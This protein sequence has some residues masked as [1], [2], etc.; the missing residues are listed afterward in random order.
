[1]DN[2]FTVST[3][4]GGG[5]F[6]EITNT[7]QPVI[8][9][10]SNP[11]YY[12]NG[13]AAVSNTTAV[14]G[15]KDTFV[16][17]YT[18]QT[19]MSG[20]V[21]LFVVP[22][23]WPEFEIDDAGQEG[24]TTYDTTGSAVIEGVDQPNNWTRTMFVRMASMAV[25]EKL[26]ITYGDT[27]GGAYPD[28][29]INVTDTPTSKV[30]FTVAA[31]DVGS[32]G[33]GL[34]N[35]ERITSQPTITLIDLG[36]MPVLGNGSAAA[37]VLYG[38][39]NMSVGLD[40]TNQFSLSVEYSDTEGDAPGYAG[41]I[42]NVI[43][44]R[45]YT[46]YN[47]YGDI[48]ISSNG[49]SGDYSN[50]FTF[51]FSTFATQKQ[52][53]YTNNA[54][55]VSNDFNTIC[56][57]ADLV[58]YRWMTRAVSGSTAPVYYPVVFTAEITI[59]TEAPELPAF[60]VVTNE[61]LS[62][63]LYVYWTNS[64][65]SDLDHYVIEYG[66]NTNPPSLNQ[67]NVGT[68]T[69]TLIDF[70]FGD[71]LYYVRL[72]AYDSM[73]NTTNSVWYTCTPYDSGPVFYSND[74]DV[75][76]YKFDDPDPLWEWGQPT[77][78][79]TA[80]SPNNCWGT[81][82][83]GD[84][85]YDN[86]DES[87]YLTNI[88]LITTSNVLM[89]FYHWYRTEEGR[90]G[91]TISVSTNNKSSWE[92]I[93]P[94]VGN[95]DAD[96]KVIGQ[97][98]FTG[99]KDKWRYV[100][101]DLTPYADNVVDIRFRFVS[102]DKENYRPG[103]YFD[104]LVIEEGIPPPAL[105]IRVNT[106]IDETYVYPGETNVEA[107][108]FRLRA[109]RSGEILSN[110]TID[111]WTWDAADT[112][113]IARVGLYRDGGTLGVYSTGDD[114][115]VT[116]LTPVG[117]NTWNAGD[118]SGQGIDIYN[119]GSGENFLVLLDISNNAPGWRRF[120]GRI[121]NTWVSSSSGLKNTEEIMNY[122]SIIVNGNVINA[123]VIDEVL[124][125]NVARGTSNAVILYFHLTGSQGG[126]TL[127]YF[128]VR[129]DWSDG[130]SVTNG[131]LDAV[132]LWHDKGGTP[133]QWDSGD[134][135][136]G[137]LGADGDTEW[138]N[139][140]S[141]YDIY[142]G[143]AGIDIILTM[144]VKTNAAQWNT[145]DARIE[146]FN[147]MSSINGRNTESLHNL[148]PDEEYY[149]ETGVMIKD[150]VIYVSMNTNFPTRNMN[151]GETNVELLAF[152][153]FEEVSSLLA[154]IR[155]YNENN[156]G[157]TSM[158]N[159][160]FDRDI[161]N[162]SLYID[163]GAQ[164]N[165]WDASDTF[166]TVLGTTNDYEWTN[167][168]PVTNIDLYNSGNGIDLLI[169]ADIP[170]SIALNTLFYARIGQSGLQSTNGADNIESLDNDKNYIAR[171]IIQPDGSGEIMNLVGTSNISGSMSNFG[172]VNIF[173]LDEGMMTNAE[174][175]IT[176]PLGFGEPQTND[177]ASN[178]YVLG[179]N[180]LDLF[181][182]NT[183]AFD[184]YPAVIS[185]GGPWT[186]TWSLGDITSSEEDQFVFGYGTREITHFDD[187]FLGNGM[188][189]PAT[190]SN[191]DFTFKS[192]NG[193][194][195][196]TDINSNYQP[197]VSIIDNTG[198]YGTGT[199]SISNTNAM[200]MTTD[201]FTITYTAETN[202]G[203]AAIMFAVPDGWDEF[204][205]DSP[206]AQGYVTVDVTG[207]AVVDDYDCIE[208][209]MGKALLVIMDTLDTN[210][211]VIVTY[212]DTSGGSY[213]QAA[214]DIIDTGT[215]YADFT[216]AAGILMEGDDGPG[217]FNFERIA[218]QPRL[219]LLPYNYPVILSNAQATAQVTSGWSNLTIEIGPTNEF[220]LTVVYADAEG[221]MPGYTTYNWSNEIYIG[222]FTNDYS[223]YSTI[224][225]PTNNGS[226]D[227]S[228]GYTFT[229]TT[230]IT[231]QIEMY[232]ESN[233][234][235]NS[236]Y[237]LAQTSSNIWYKWYAYGFTGNTA[238]VEFPTNS[239]PQIIVDDTAPALP[240]SIT[241]TNEN[242]YHTLNIYWTNSADTNDLYYYEVEYRTN[243]NSG[244]T[245]FTNTDT[246]T[247]VSISDLIGY[248]N[249]YVRL[250]AYDE[251]GNNTNSIWYECFSRDHMPVLTNLSASATSNF[252]SN[253]LSIQTGK[254]NDF[255]LSV[256]YYDED[257]DYP[258]YT[259]LNFTNMIFL[260]INT[261]GF[262]YGSI[263][264][265]TNSTNINW[266]NGYVFSN[267]MTAMETNV[268]YGLSV[269][270]NTLYNL[271][272]TI[273]NLGYRWSAA[274]MTGDPV[275]VI[276]PSGYIPQIVIDSTPP[277]M[278]VYIETTNDGPFFSID[279]YWTNSTSDDLDHFIVEY[280]TN[281]N[282]G[283]VDYTNTGTITNIS[284]T[285]L[286]GNT[287]YYLRL[288]TYDKYD[289]SSNSVWYECISIDD[290]PIIYSNDFENN[291][292]NFNNPD[293][294]TLWEY[295]DLSVFDAHSTNKCWGTVLN[296]YYGEASADYSLY[297]T[298]IYLLSTTNIKLS[299]WFYCD[300]PLDEAGAS[301]S[302]R[303]QGGSYELMH[304][305]VSIYST[306]VAGLGGP[307]YSEYEIDW[308]LA[309][310][311]LTPYAN[312]TVDIRWRFASAS[313]DYYEAGFYVDDVVIEEGIPEQV[314]NTRI[315]KYYDMRILD[316]GI[317]NEEFLAF[318]IE[319]RTNNQDLLAL[320]LWND[321]D[322]A[323]T[324]N[325]IENIQL[326]LDGG[327]IGFFEP[328]PDTYITNLLPYDTTTWRHTGIPAGT[329]IYN[330]G[331]GVDLLIT[332]DIKSNAQ[333]W[334]G[335]RGRFDPYMMASA[336][337]L[338]NIHRIE[339]N[340]D[341]VI[342]GNV[343]LANVV[344]RVPWTNVVRGT[345]NFMILY[346][347]MTGS[348]NGEE[349]REAQVENDWK[350]SDKVEES[351]LDA[352]KLWNDEGDIP[353][354]WD[355]N[356][357]YIGQL[358][359]DGSTRWT[360]GNLSNDIYNG[361]AGIDVLLT[362]DVATNAT[363]GRVM[364]VRIGSFDLVSSIGAGNI[365]QLNN[366]ENEYDNNGESGIM[367]L[368]KIIYAYANTNFPNMNYT[369]GETNVPLLA[370]HAFEDVAGARLMRIMLENDN[371]QGQTQMS[372]MEYGR[373]ITN[374]RLYIDSGSITN[375]WDS[376]DALITEFST[377]NSSEW[378]NVQAVTNIDLYNGGSGIDL[379]ITADI[380][381]SIAI[382]T[383]FEA[384]IGFTSLLSTNG[385]V[386]MDSINNDGN[387]IA[388]F[389]IQPDGAGVA[390]RIIGL[391]NISGSTSN[392][393]F[394]MSFGIPFGIMTNAD[395]R[396]TIPSNFGEPQNTN[397]YDYNYVQGFKYG[398]IMDHL[399]NEY[400]DYPAS[401]AGS[402]PWTVTWSIG[403]T[404]TDM[405]EFFIISYGARELIRQADV[406]LGDGIELP[407]IVS[408]V[409]LTIES[410]NGGGTFS[411][412]NSNNQPYMSIV[413]NPGH[414][415][416]GTCTVSNAT[417]MI[418][419]T[420]TFI[421]TYA[422]ETNM[423]GASI[424][425]SVPPGWTGFELDQIGADGY[426]TYETTG[427]AEVDD[428][429]NYWAGHVVFFR[430]ASM[431][432]GEKLIL[433]YGDTNGGMYPAAA[434]DVVS[435]PND[436]AEFQIAA[437]HALAGQ[438][439]PQLFNFER[440]LS[441]PY[442]ALEWPN[443][444]PTLT[445][446]QVTA[447]A[448]FGPS[449]H[450]V[451]AGPTNTITLSVVYADDDGDI[452][453][454]A[455]LTNSNC[456]AIDINTNAN[457]SNT[458]YGSILVPTNGGS[459]DY[460][461]GYTF[462]FTTVMTQDIEFI[463]ESNTWTNT[464]YDLYNTA[465]ITNIY[466]IWWAE[467]LTGQTNGVQAPTSYSAE[468]RITDPEI[469]VTESGAPYTNGGSPYD[470]GQV[471][472]T[473]TN[474][475]TFT[476][477]NIGNGD[478]DLTGTPLVAIT[479]ADASSF[480]VTTPPPAL[481]TATNSVTFELSFHPTTE[482]VLNAVIVI[483]N[484][485]FNEPV[486]QFNV[487][488]E[489]FIQP[490]GYALEFDGTNDYVDCGN[491]LSNAF[492]AITMEAWIRLP[493]G[494]DTNTYSHH[495]IASKGPNVGY[496]SIYND[497][498][499]FA[500][501]IDGAQT[502]TEG[503]KIVSGGEWHHVA[504]SWDSVSDRY[505]T[506]FDGEL[507][508]DTIHAG[509]AINASTDKLFIGS[510]TGG[511]YLF[512]GFIDEVRIWSTERSPVDLRENMGK[513]VVSNE[514][515]LLA[516]YKFDHM[517][518]TSL[519]DIGTNNY[520]GVLSNMAGTEWTNSEA[521][522][523]TPKILPANDVTAN[524]FVANWETNYCATKYFLDV[525]SNN[526]STFLAGYNDLDVG[527]MHTNA[528]SGLAAGYYY[529]R[530]RAYNSNTSRTSDNSDYYVV[531][532]GNMPEIQVNRGA[533]IF[534]NEMVT[535][536]FGSITA[537]LSI[538]NTF[539]IS[540][541]GSSTLNLTGTPIVLS[542]DSNLFTVITQP[543]STAVSNNSVD[544]QIAF[545]P[546]NGGYQIAAIIIS[547]SDMVNE[548]YTFYATGYSY[549]LCAYYPFNSNA[550]D[551]SGNDNDPVYNYATL[552]NDRYED[553]DSAYHTGS[554]YITIP[555][556]PDLDV[557]GALTISLWARFDSVDDWKGLIS[558]S[559]H[560]GS[561]VN[562]AYL[563]KVWG[564]SDRFNFW[565]T[566]SGDE[567]LRMDEIASHVFPT[568]E[569]HHYAVVYSP[570]S[571]IKM[572]VDGNVDLNDTT[573]IRPSIYNSSRPLRIGV[574][575]GNDSGTGPG[576]N[577]K[578]DEVRIY[579]Q[580]FS[581]TQVQQ[582]AARPDM[583]ILQSGTSYPSGGSGFNFGSIKTNTTT[584]YTFTITNRG[585]ADLLLT[586]TP[587][588]FIT[589]ADAGRFTIVSQPGTNDISGLSTTIFELS[590][591]PTNVRPYS[592]TLVVSNNDFDDNFVYS[593]TIDGSGKG[594][595]AYYP[596]AS[597]A[598]DASGNN[599]NGTVNDALSTNDRY[600][601]L[602]NAYFFD[603]NDDFI[604]YGEQ[605]E[606]TF[607]GS[608]KKFTIAAWINV[609]STNNHIILGK[610]SDSLLG[611][612]QRQFTFSIAYKEP[613]FSW[614]SAPIATIYRVIAA[615]NE[616]QTNMWYHVTVTYDGTVMTG[617]GIDRINLFT[618]AVASGKYMVVQNG[619]LSDICN[620]SAPIA[621][622]AA[623]NVAETQAE[624]EFDG[625]IDEV[626]VYNYILNQQ[627]IEVLAAKP[628]ILIYESGTLITNSVS[629]FDFGTT[630]AGSSNT[631]TFTISNTGLQQLDLNGTPRVDIVGAGADHFNI[632][633]LPPASV[634]ETNSETFQISFAPTNGGS[635]IATVIISN[636]DFNNS[637]YS[638]D[639][640][641]TSLGLIAYYPFDGNTLD[642]SGNNNDLAVSNA[643]LSNDRYDNADTS[644]YL[645]G[646]P[647]SRMLGSNALFIED[648]Y[649]IA[650]WYKPVTGGGA[651][652][653]LVGLYEE[654]AHS[655]VYVWSARYDAEDNAVRYVH[656]VP[657]G[658]TGGSS[659]F[660]SNSYTVDSW[661]HVA[662][663]YDGTQMRVYQDGQL[664]STMLNPSTTI[665]DA[666]RVY[667]GCNGPYTDA[668]FAYKG[669]L[670]EVR[671]YNYD[672]TDSEIQQL[673]AMPSMG[674]MIS[675]T[676]Y[677]SGYEF[678]DY[679]TTNIGGSNNIVFTITNK[680]LDDLYL[681]G[682]PELVLTGRDTEHFTISAMPGITN[683]SG[684]SNTTFEVAFTPTNYGIRI[685]TVVISNND[686]NNSVYELH[687]QG[688]VEGLFAYYPFDGSALDV[689]G[690]S[691]DLDAYNVALTNDRYGTNNSAYYFNGAVGTYMMASNYY[692][693]NDKYTIA[694]WYCADTNGNT[695][696]SL[697][698]FYD[699]GNK[700]NVYTFAGLYDAQDNAARFLHRVPP[701]ISSADG[702]NVYVSNAYEE[703]EWHHLAVRYDGTEMQ[704]YADGILYPNTSSP[705][706]TIYDE[707]RMYLGKNG[708]SDNP[709]MFNK[710]WL[711]DVRVYNTVLSPDVISNLAAKPTILVY[712][713]GTE[714]TNGGAAFD[715]G[716]VNVGLSNIVTFTLSNIG[717][718]DLHITGNPRVAITG[719]D[720]SHF[721]VNT[722]PPSVVTQTNFA[723]YKIAFR[724][725]ANGSKT[726]AIVITN[727]DFNNPVYQYTV[728]GTGL[729]IV[730][731][732]TNIG[733]GYTNIQMAI[734]S[735]SNGHTVLVYDGIHTGPIT[736]ERTN[737]HL[738][739]SS[740]FTSTNNTGAI[741]DAAGS[742]TGVLF[743]NS[744]RST[745]EGF[746][747]IGA[748]TNGIE[749]SENSYSNRIVH[750][751]I[752]SNAENGIYCRFDTADS[753]EIASNE[754]FGP[755]QKYGFYT[756][757]ADN[758]LILSNRFH[759]HSQVAIV[760][761]T[762]VANSF[763]E[764]NK[765]YDN[766]QNGIE[767]NNT[768]QWN[769]VR[770]N[771][772]YDNAGAG[773]NIQFNAAS[774]NSIV[775]NSIFGTNQA[776]GI[777]IIRGDF[778]KIFSNRIYSNNTYGVHI[779]LLAMSNT[780]ENNN[781]FE[782]DTGV[783]FDSS[784]SN[785][786]VTDNRIYDNTTYGIHIASED[787]DNIQ[788]TYNDIYDNKSTGIYIENGDRAYI[789]TNMISN[790]VSSG[791]VIR[792]AATD[793]TIEK[794]TI[795][796][797]ATYGIY[798]V[799]DSADNN[800]IK[801]NTIFGVN[802]DDGIRIDSSDNT[803]IHSNQIL[804]NDYNGI[805]IMNASTNNSIIGNTV[806]NNPSRGIILFGADA[807]DNI[808]SYNTIRNGTYGIYFNDALSNN[809]FLNTVTNYSTYGI[810]FQNGNE[811]NR[812]ELNN[813][814]DNAKDINS[815][816]FSFISNYWGSMH[817]PTIQ[818]DMDEKDTNAV[819]PFRFG[820]IGI[821]QSNVMPPPAPT[822]TSAAFIDTN[823]IVS[824]DPSGGDTAGYRIYRSMNAKTW[825]NFSAPYADLGNVTSYTDSTVGYNTNYFYYI[826][827]YDS[828]SPLTNESWYSAP[829]T[830]SLG[831]VA[832]NTNNNLVYG[833]I[834][835]AV[836]D[837]GLNH[838]IVV[839]SNIL[840][841]NVII[842]NNMDVIAWD[843][844]VS[845]DNTAMLI[846]GGGGSYCFRVNSA[847]VDIKGFTLTNAGMGGNGIVMYMGGASGTIES[848]R[849]MYNNN[850]AVQVEDS[851]PVI[852]YNYIRNTDGIRIKNNSYAQVIENTI[853][854]ANSGISLDSVTNT[855]WII[856][857]NTIS[858]CYT[859][860][861][862]NNFTFG[863]SNA[864]TNNTITYNSDGIYIGNAND[865]GVVD[866][867]LTGNTNNGINISGSV[868]NIYV[869][870][871]TITGSIYGVQC[872]LVNNIDVIENTIN[873]SITNAVYIKSASDITVRGNN[874]S[875]TA[876]GSID[877]NTNSTGIKV[878]SNTISATALYGIRIINETADN[879][880]IASN[881]ITGSIQSVG[882]H[883]QYGD[884][885]T[886][887]QNTLISNYTGIR[888]S[889]NAD[890]NTLTNNTVS[891]GYNGIELADVLSN[892]VISNAVYSASNDA[893]SMADAAGTTVQNN[894]LY[895]NTNAVE[896]TGMSYNNS[897]FN[898]TVS[899]NVLMGI[900]L[901]GANVSNNKIMMN[902]VFNN[903]RSI[904]LVGAVDAVIASNTVYNNADYGISVGG[905]T[906]ITVYENRIFGHAAS[907]GIRIKDS[908]S[909]GT[910]NTLTNNLTGM[911]IEG[912]STVDYAYNLI[913][914]NSATN[915]GQIG[916]LSTIYVSNTWFG[917]LSYTSAKS[918]LFNIADS[919][920]V[921]YRLGVIGLTQG[922]ILAP[923][924]PTNG[925]ALFTGSN[926]IIAWDESGGSPSGY[927]VYKSITIDTWTNFTAYYTN[928]S[929]A[930]NTS[931]TDENLGINTNYYYYITSY[932]SASPN[933]NE[934]WYSASISAH[935]LI[936]PEIYSTNYSQNDMV[937]GNITLAGVVTNG[938]EL[939]SELFFKTNNTGYSPITLLTNITTNW[940]T[941]NYNTSS[942]PD[943]TNTFTF[944][945][946]DTYAQTNTNTLKLLV[947]NST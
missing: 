429:I 175:E 474:T 446:M 934:S 346:F 145:M 266:T 638:F 871:N 537:G 683:I 820:M 887:L 189:C 122:R 765:I 567:T 619:A 931:F 568:G 543:G 184:D 11:G 407:A 47:E 841:E 442:I 869:F 254:T 891:F 430:M 398:A 94:D 844:L 355:T 929:G 392:I 655:N 677:A 354:V 674:I 74:F 363:N 172:F 441:H 762:A 273:T 22:D 107:L 600:G 90:A 91:L 637:V 504:C 626:R 6:V 77:K 118:L 282:S 283:V 341:S 890:Y 248:Q 166:I 549:G 3:R 317:T 488:G 201:T 665:N 280:R 226:G 80:Y 393:G 664:Y 431:A 371:Q 513:E 218:S 153:A 691:Y 901:I 700:S 916:N 143:G 774:N 556:D 120:N 487:T 823:I 149:D 632:A 710:G 675:G 896:I 847:D 601:A 337:G 803:K 132:K 40:P 753:T 497:K 252:G 739:A 136:I 631:V 408:N 338:S 344:E 617:N 912:I 445:N 142:N 850:D 863:S 65:S 684:Y 867:T 902:T 663:R 734:N 51:N 472:L 255:T 183:N 590:F 508:V 119:S 461:N 268:F 489:G 806:E 432:A 418:G 868:S 611:E 423:D 562:T 49:G 311:D 455:D 438:Y 150:K 512:N 676:E 895:Q 539:T 597:N 574:D 671:I 316:F 699:E 213:P 731:S 851:S 121:S 198:Q 628:T 347:H 190:V 612:D 224:Q 529:Y 790:N 798:I 151:G 789:Y 412:I 67:K 128:R 428:I 913:T 468:I 390:S 15:S 304:P 778:N 154:S 531:N 651:S 633:A 162:V 768:S 106:P 615:S 540:N 752:Y 157:D 82:L 501:L 495:M 286:L 238:V 859:G 48:I 463:T 703:R 484:S 312:E 945:V 36:D 555:D 416:S 641:G 658:D 807:Q 909:D 696:D 196:L 547:N 9:V 379:L 35:F 927:H 825:T 819:V 480:S 168:S 208:G 186:V 332:F 26:I 223:Y 231:Q 705:A 421:L 713:S 805:Q 733:Q 797:N 860:I 861:N 31:G 403:N 538:T 439:G 724:P 519:N 514:S 292:S 685:A 745:I 275:W 563:I 482:A 115:F 627:E 541:I 374:V 534:S 481:V 383:C 110:I 523:L 609:S 448:T 558:K 672:I 324:T 613:K 267:T 111:N 104:D 781:I 203:G 754:I 187:G 105:N 160:I 140:G 230:H 623:V 905:S 210:E 261:N 873:N 409:E 812:I 214:V 131:D 321:A 144:D 405:E 103:Y 64:T 552:T 369:G 271:S 28:A 652:S 18:A 750:N 729:Q 55:F 856:S 608:D 494:Y 544:F 802:Q 660:A 852:R 366:W 12:G 502:Y 241:V 127:E 170:G 894:S 690:N 34:Y 133:G 385:A 295:G 702:S 138:T 498:A 45:I 766:S 747:I 410:R 933:M 701:S 576:V 174:I 68:D 686:F 688:T 265:Y 141:G 636:S 329:D 342:N 943:G 553:S 163:S 176:I 16:I 649:T 20:R 662:I 533:E 395:V 378:T 944:Y 296:S 359:A 835:A 325:D 113:D 30:V 349:L 414:Y 83:D 475:V 161:T 258:G 288:H 706:T 228:N 736:I 246:N 743:T 93:T 550:N 216:V 570:S 227:Y 947:D 89:R 923:D 129:N 926:V 165:L 456:I 75:D 364:D 454:F 575:V 159:M 697:A 320:E 862:I 857:G 2:E 668:A 199:A 435:C 760:L 682:N 678:I 667:L 244:I 281:T 335:I 659:F 490:P 707:V 821:N 221:D 422:A 333:G 829:A 419:S 457:S 215:N 511:D 885:N 919:N 100:I 195:T 123:Y 450:S 808:I 269:Y 465:D 8:S 134:S 351:D 460:T 583:L 101:F 878:L 285:G 800:T 810:Y 57:N 112:N 491:G 24:Y 582:L 372:N 571:Y 97:E 782:N 786:T 751:R 761:Q 88:A 38:T 938:S 274:A 313:P 309:E 185:G 459:G 263:A 838:T 256:K 453:G 243:T 382:N 84:Y 630:N 589:G 420:N 718:E 921:P 720:A 315:T 882:I 297:L 883:I 485:D 117:Y 654:S 796:S 930:A 229:F 880:I 587:E 102:G 250:F 622:G 500:P 521:M 52:A 449:N 595:V 180:L 910:Q 817:W 4:N 327:A 646:T 719:A 386:N 152:H 424:M 855:N 389:F 853:E 653:G 579:N 259:A 39:S 108:S 177:H 169:T 458:Y 299:F 546:T 370:F 830:G 391:T 87:L 715:F 591:T 343:I 875:S 56:Q 139:S 738:L 799:I 440:I 709:I 620:A 217:I 323:A 748:A 889:S 188:D 78:Y 109:N 779:D 551:A 404:S 290:G 877:I 257:G 773:V 336:S 741:L 294:G 843:W 486:Y 740:W 13:S 167:E 207:S 815:N 260:T 640:T 433:T 116:N 499:F 284:M 425:F 413:N 415:G 239:S 755:D 319:T 307:G 506:Y 158:S 23:G 647:G 247:N 848:N 46:N 566:E 824:W 515:G 81:E 156:E 249:Y 200:I 209:S 362:M 357:T 367:I 735:A 277:D 858:N 917:S 625:L 610:L 179:I 580:A 618:D 935:V 54:F 471:D 526:F 554:G 236:I 373:D 746:G 276:R 73:S 728:T 614:Y 58:T 577:A 525:S 565:A 561:Y 584:N 41:L 517:S 594:L 339:N 915:L 804:E 777:H 757:Q 842:A 840:N 44:L 289:N 744:F 669:F 496:M 5:T 689:S 350:N 722:L 300:V 426:T 376:G 643:V 298:N 866:N 708:M 839:F 522:M 816:T 932:D 384:H 375:A 348:S 222:L 178:N 507:D 795:V 70:L 524:S 813:I 767:L 864:I 737:L 171:F 293:A 704:V 479:G 727:S 443:A 492:G 730:A 775:S 723:A 427:T 661:H 881:E 809:I 572:Y 542:T 60:I 303:T 232:G 352:V 717:Y 509:N 828:A 322:N 264:V 642:A 711:D 874:I 787:A 884:N 599:F 503:S 399:T 310:F 505:R 532:V 693:V 616:I 53:F 353:G 287:K 148:G 130:N 569:W 716:S 381:N 211:Q 318:H 516:Y 770:Y 831:G 721:T 328:G 656:R 832:S 27:S 330:S 604:T 573:G 95:Y 876:V 85:E 886:V 21:I 96:I 792:T 361:G 326:W 946:V 444:L 114:T 451:A 833:S 14:I 535:A 173:G 478:L 397:A 854:K 219:T 466:Y 742:K 814:F 624:Y 302:L 434:V 37:Q 648:P 811:Y 147:I 897:L 29:A 836:D 92:Y 536:S 262:G 788:I 278:P 253:N 769:T 212:G 146:N 681:T 581:D 530:I 396:I 194:G 181:D 42:T 564:A 206:S 780:V 922:D 345:S 634:G 137:Q 377:T 826:T 941:N 126:E 714:Y 240:V 467:A 510:H 845:A 870:D 360:N 388:R 394:F 32:V 666:V 462:I 657:A 834:Q 725:T 71:M 72:Y 772:I 560:T 776:I 193:G 928:L 837:A 237:D 759:D 331:N 470:F 17:T 545:N 518:G 801:Y 334:R 306:N 340:E 380:V 452:P 272:L 899:D 791:V 785:N 493:E 903:Y 192:R 918:R 437:G 477:S 892:T 483:T 771:D 25:G 940:F 907:T 763:I 220:T 908:I 301:V 818:S 603:G 598:N 520:D 204:N 79:L 197:V 400:N 593:L 749:I 469:L 406:F 783:Y 756:V 559:L 865:I 245:S 62:N 291:A 645:N 305:E 849:L 1:G 732:N 76:A 585:L 365:S 936:L 417:A 99:I 695:V 191:Y 135:N 596:F 202:M 679:G 473:A 937:T 846:D 670:D 270:T 911:L 464:L 308:K 726:A 644:Y 687:L 125:T 356:D 233:Y 942:L 66:T 7:G 794:N 639:I 19:N 888:I 650:Y 793:N 578:L 906:N 98:G 827:A 447:P 242:L 528:L 692:I 621:V 86:A 712:Q 586:E 784:S 924:I 822:N 476:I 63:A 436:K 879:N 358:F 402:G 939:L 368:D 548:G 164:T 694:L 205:I 50:G 673:A 629:M 893:L 904:D 69:N 59:D 607:A 411:N 872:T 680:S 10:V 900:R 387:C 225:V 898:N 592:A 764:Y 605:Y 235:T 251:F 557:T 43:F 314:I 606:G 635:K 279:M 124:R 61:G 401:I 698:G 914:D 527:Y 182:I 758:I 33:Y 602:S 925:S 234:F 155:F 920:F 588:M